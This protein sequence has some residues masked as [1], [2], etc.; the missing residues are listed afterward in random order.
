MIS[1]NT[2]YTIYNTDHPA[3]KIFESWVWNVCN[4]DKKIKLKIMNLTF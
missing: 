4:C 2:G 1:K 3:V